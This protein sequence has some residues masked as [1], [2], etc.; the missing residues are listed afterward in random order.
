[1]KR[2]AKLL[3]G[4]L[5]VIF[6]SFALT[7]WLRSDR[8]RVE[9]E[10]FLFVGSDGHRISGEICRPVGAVPDSPRPAVI[11]CAGGNNSHSLVRNLNAELARAGYVVLTYSSY[12]HGDSDIAQTDTMGADEVLRYIQTLDFVDQQQIGV[13]GHTRGS[14]YLF[15]AALKSGHVRAAL[16]LDAIDL[17][18]S[19]TGYSSDTPIHCGWVMSNYNEFL[20]DP[21]AYR[22]DAALQ[23]LFGTKTGPVPGQVY[24]TGGANALRV[25]YTV[26]STDSGYPYSVGYVKAMLDFFGRTLDGANAAFSGRPVW[27]LLELLG[28]VSLGGLLIAM[29]CLARLLLA[30]LALILPA[31]ALDVQTVKGPLLNLRGVLFSILVTALPFLPLFMLGKRILTPN[32]LF[33]QNDTNGLAIWGF[34]AAI[35]YWGLLTF[36]QGRRR[37]LEWALFSMTGSRRDI[38]CAFFAAAAVFAGAYLLNMAGST[39]FHTTFRFLQTF[40]EPLSFRRMLAACVYFPIFALYFLSAEGFRAERL[41]AHARQQPAEYG[42]GILFYAGGF[43]LLYLVNFIGFPLQGYSLF[44]PA[45]FAFGPILSITPALVLVGIISVW[46]H[47]KTGRIYFSCFLNTFL[48]VWLLVGSNAFYYT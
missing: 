27:V 2:E 25:L 15:K 35:L 31:G 28:A 29:L 23:R 14:A 3:A 20:T 6:A 26:N 8:G 34:F 17:L 22:T 48:I 38:G 7:A 43:V 40:F 46:G 4:A 11:T 44:H 33:P 42:Y 18:G 24:S 32:L 41:S 10:P 13:M 39:A 9:I 12:K 30:R 45:R 47:R 5:V 21:R 19:L 37:P 16:S 36:L 1:M